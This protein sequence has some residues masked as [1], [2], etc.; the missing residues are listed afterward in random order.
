MPCTENSPDSFDDIMVKKGEVIDYFE[1]QIDPNEDLIFITWSPDPKEMPDSDFY[2]QHQ[3]NVKILADYA[4]ACSLC[5]WCVESTMLGIPHYHGWYQIRDSTE[6]SRIAIIKTLQR[7]GR[8]KVTKCE[9]SYKINN[10]E[11]RKNGLYYY[12]KDLLDSMIEMEPNPIISTSETTVNF[13]TLDIVGFFSKEK[14][15]M[16]TLKDKV[17]DRKFFRDFYSNT[18]STVN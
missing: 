6:L 5:V 11:E 18:L 2:L 16:K 12:K 1:S 17:S 15:T 9:R 4:K 3:V 8:V 10:Y 13:D 7:F 14:D